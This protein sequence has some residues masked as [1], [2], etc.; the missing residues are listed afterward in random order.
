MVGKQLADTV[1]D[2]LGIEKRIVAEVVSDSLVFSK[3]RATHPF[4]DGVTVPVIHDM[5]VSLDEGTAFVHCAPAAVLPTMML[6]FEIISK[7]FPQ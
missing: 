7:F 5:S 6:G 4:I 2:K 1:A 3:V